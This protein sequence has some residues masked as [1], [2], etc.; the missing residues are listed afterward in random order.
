MCKAHIGNSS[1]EKNRRPA[2]RRRSEQAS[3]IRDFPLAMVRA[4]RGCP[5]ERK[6]ASLV[7]ARSAGGRAF[8]GMP[9]R[10]HQ[11]SLMVGRSFPSASYDGRATHHGFDFP[12]TGGSPAPFYG[13]LDVLGAARGNSDVPT[14]RRWC[15]SFHT[16]AAYSAPCGPELDVDPDSASFVLLSA[17]TR[18]LLATLTRISSL[19]S[20]QHSDPTRPAFLGLVEVEGVLFGVGR[21][22]G[23][24]GAHGRQ[25]FTETVVPPRSFGSSCIEAW[26]NLGW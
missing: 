11:P 13:P 14:P 23:A 8:V 12:V 24:A 21:I 5:Y 16:W 20:P 2:A 1:A 10:I 6:A 4:T 3:P 15:R 25:R 22:E 17:E 26:R 9:T 18:T 7:A 19:F